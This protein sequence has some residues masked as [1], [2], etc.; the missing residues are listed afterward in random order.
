MTKNNNVKPLRII[1]FHAENIMAIKAID[2][3]PE[4][5]DII[6]LTGQNRNG[7]SSVLRAIYAALA[8]KKFLPEEAIRRGQEKGNISLDLGDFIITLNLT[9]KGESLKVETK[10]KMKP[11]GGPQGFLNSRLANLA[12]NPLEFMRLKPVEQVKIVQELFPLNV[13][14]GKVEEVAGLLAKTVSGEGVLYLDNVVSKLFE[15][16][17]EANREVKRL[18]K[19]IESSVVPP[20]L[21]DIEAVSVTE[22]FEE[23]KALEETKREND[24]T[25]TTA[26]ALDTKLDNIGMKIQGKD[27]EIEKLEARLIILKE[28]RKALSDGYLEDTKKSLKEA[29]IVDALID[30]NFTEIDEKITKA[31]E[32]N[33]DAAKAEQIS[34]TLKQAKIDLAASQ[35]D[36]KDLTKQIES[37]KTY[38]LK[39]IE[40]A[41]L[42]LPDLGFENGQLTY[43]NLPLDVASTREQIEIS[44]A[45]CLAQHPKIGIITV[46]RGWADLDESGKQALRQFARNTGAQIWVTVVTEAP[47]NDGFHIVD[48]ELAAVDGVLLEEETEARQ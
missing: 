24:L 19:V 1:K 39:L 42:P 8:G 15:E 21:R 16:R 11:S 9:A 33:K 3:Y 4:D 23:R 6:A 12:H 35:K 29:T 41:Q 7:K 31:D 46:D 27:D 28:E 37:L 44:C 48:G 40:Q 2:I 36:S 45:L 22:L 32:N 10:D 47:S 5:K 43:N 20:D 17:T 38:K 26:K 34:T 14:A 30:P 25:R 13:E 18:E